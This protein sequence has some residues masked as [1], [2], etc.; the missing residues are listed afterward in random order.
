[1]EVS[2]KRGRFELVEEEQ[3]G[4]KLKQVTESSSKSEWNFE[5]Y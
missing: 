2:L 1:L 3:G 5:K 4:K